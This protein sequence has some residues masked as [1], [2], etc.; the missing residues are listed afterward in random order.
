VEFVAYV[1]SGYSEVATE[2]K[3]YFALDLLTGDVIASANVGNRGGLIPYENALVSGPVA[4]NELTLSNRSTAVNPAE[5]VSTRVYFND[6][7][8]R[9][10]RVKTEDPGTVTELA[11]VNDGA[12]T[13]LHPLGVSPALVFYGD[14]NA[15]EYPHIYIE[16]GNDNRIF[17]PDAVPAT[18]PPFKAWGLV[19]RDLTSDPD[20]GDG[21]VGPVQVIFTK[22]FPNLYRGTTQ[23]A[24]AFNEAG[25]ARVL[26]AGTRF[27]PPGTQFAPPPP[28]C[29]SSF[30]SILFA[31][32]A[33][34]GNAAFDLNASGQDEYVEYMQQQ[35]KSVQVVGGQAIVDRG[36]NAEIAPTP[37]PSNTIA[38]PIEGSVFQGLSVPDEF[39]VSHRETPFSLT[40]TVCR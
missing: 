25:L 28:P 1:G 6:I 5:T 30:D 26:F 15:Q 35:I 13:V 3:R 4:F 7:H 33:G 24:T 37:P 38:P 12:T 40:S 14:A 22:S 32:G 18:T 23:P 39:V 34:T 29:R 11:D 21:V 27:N 2:G 36:L 9:L 19:D 16:S 31:L 17:S 10:F 20:S 8:G